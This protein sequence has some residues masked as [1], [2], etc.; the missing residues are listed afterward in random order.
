MDT[1][2][3]TED[4][5][6]AYAATVRC[7]KPDCAITVVEYG[8][9]QIRVEL[10]GISEMFDVREICKQYRYG[11]KMGDECMRDEL[12]LYGF[13]APAEEDEMEERRRWQ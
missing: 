9:T 1:K 8:G 13:A 12:A 6:I 2:D 5:A 4:V 11:E 7:A 3:M 10:K